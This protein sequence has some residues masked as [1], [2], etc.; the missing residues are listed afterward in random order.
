VRN[1]HDKAGR[2]VHEGSAWDANDEF[3]KGNPDMFA[4]DE[5]A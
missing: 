1:Y 3:V 2:I 5:A 4:P